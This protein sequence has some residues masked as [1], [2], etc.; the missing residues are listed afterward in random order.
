[1]DAVL[2]SDLSQVVLVPNPAAGAG[3]T[4][5]PSGAEFTRIR[6]VCFQL[7]TSS[8]VANRIVYLD[9]VD[10]SGAK[11]ARSSAGF[12]QT[13]SLTSVY[14]FAV[15]INTYGANAAASIGSGL[16]EI[17]LRNGCEISVGI[18]A[19]DTADQ[20]SAIRVT[21]DQVGAT[22]PTDG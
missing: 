3:F 17:W 11:I 9:L 18:T 10:G 4:W 8:A 12:N 16:P 13:A 1:M 22:A 2:Q 21:V 6:A 5:K 14:T 7:V 19:V 20:V 15:G